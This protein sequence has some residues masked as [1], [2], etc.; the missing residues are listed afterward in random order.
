MTDRHHKIDGSC[1]H[2]RGVREWWRLGEWVLGKRVGKGIG[3]W[4]TWVGEGD[5]I[6]QQEMEI[7]CEG[8]EGLERSD[9]YGCEVWGGGGGVMHVY[10]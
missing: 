5:V 3:C 4:V 6:D 7:S 8:M 1:E 2:G 10:I 9:I